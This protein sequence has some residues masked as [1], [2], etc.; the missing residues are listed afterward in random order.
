M[1]VR[2]Y[3]C[4]SHSQ[5]CILHEEVRR[6]LEEDDEGD[7]KESGAERRARELALV[8][9]LVQHREEVVAAGGVRAGVGS[10]PTIPYQ[11]I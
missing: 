10:I 5:G 3:V 1:Y 9:L 8:R 11:T 4:T 7:E 2:M 6:D